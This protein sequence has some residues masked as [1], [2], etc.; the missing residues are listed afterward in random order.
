MRRS[1]KGPLIVILA[2]VVLIAAF[3]IWNLNSKKE[4]PEQNGSSVKETVSPSNESSET[5]EPVV[6][7]EDPAKTGDQEGDDADEE[8]PVEVEVGEELEII[9][10]EGQESGGF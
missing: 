1:K 6:E 4:A 5:E 9:V 8:E 2:A 3:A 10:P 7:T